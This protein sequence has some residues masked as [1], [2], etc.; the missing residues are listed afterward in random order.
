MD[1]PLLLQE[2]AKQNNAWSRKHL[3]PLE[4]KKR[5]TM[6]DCT[7]HQLFFMMQT[8]LEVRTESF[9]SEGIILSLAATG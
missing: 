7:M 6:E 2:G 5:N 8:H 1:L 3:M 9:I 4:Q